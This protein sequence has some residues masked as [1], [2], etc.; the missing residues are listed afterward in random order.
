MSTGVSGASGGVSCLS[1][2]KASEVTHDVIGAPKRLCAWLGL[3]VD[4][5]ELSQTDCIRSKE[6]NPLT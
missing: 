1:N 5:C 2:K 6:H 3:V 4:R